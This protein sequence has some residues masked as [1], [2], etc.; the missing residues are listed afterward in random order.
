MPAGA[1]LTFSGARDGIRAYLAVAGGIDVPL[2][3]GSRSTLTKARLGGF[4]GR[5]LAAGDRVP[6]GA[7]A[8]AELR[9]GWRMPRDV[10]PAYGHAHTAPRRVGS[11]R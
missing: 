7:C 6:V 10:V 8:G 9:A 3:L 4:L 5:A 1:A 2:V 11:P